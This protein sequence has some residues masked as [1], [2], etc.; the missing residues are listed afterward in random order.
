MPKFVASYRGF[1]PTVAG[2]EDTPVAIGGAR[3]I[4]HLIVTLCIILDVVG[5]ITV[6]LAWAFVHAGILAVGTQIQVLGRVF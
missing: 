3:G 6:G 5:G 4:F 1:V 2:V